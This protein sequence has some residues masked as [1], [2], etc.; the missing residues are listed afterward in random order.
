MFK[1]II[2]TVYFLIVQLDH[3][4]TFEVIWNVPT[5]EC[6]KRNVT[7]FPELLKSANITFNSKDMFRGEKI[8]IF[9]SPG[10]WP[11]LEH[12]KVQNG[13]LP[14]KAN[15]TLH[16]DRFKQQIEEAIEENFSGMYG[17][18]KVGQLKCATSF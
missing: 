5:Q 2:P 13:G 15:L 1:W 6:L 16:I 11:S 18:N 12:K 8:H 14:Y 7:E 3:G 17:R 9:Y 10:I 4:R